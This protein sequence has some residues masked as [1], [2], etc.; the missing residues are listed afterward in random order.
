MAMLP[1]KAVLPAL[2]LSALVALTGCGSVG[3]PDG[4]PIV[5]VR[6]LP[7]NPD[8]VEVEFSGCDNSP[9][10]DVLESESTVRITLAGPN[11]G[12]EP[13]YELVVELQEPLGDRTVVDGATGNELEVHT[14]SSSE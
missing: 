4:Q 9:A 7:D 10:V 6:L 11:P 1:R 14:R 13:I 12:C 5:G 2:A 3:A 8:A